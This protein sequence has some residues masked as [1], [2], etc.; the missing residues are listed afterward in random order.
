MSKTKPI[1]QTLPL[2]HDPTIRGLEVVIS[3]LLRA[4]VIIS[5][6]LIAVGAIAMFAQHPEYL[7]SST[8]P[9]RIL[10]QDAKLPHSLR[11]LLVR[12]YELRGDAIITL[13]LLVLM[14]TPML[15]VAVSVLTFIRHRDGIYVLITAT[16]FCLLM[17]SLVLGGIE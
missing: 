2:H 3:K 16:V 4:G 12:L 13:G 11:A 1:Q 6:A 15:R 14:A 9:G 8:H 7:S 5:V 17:L 10:A